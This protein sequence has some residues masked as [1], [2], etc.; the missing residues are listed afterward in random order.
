MRR[1]TRT[2]ITPPRL[3]SL[4]AARS[5]L[6]YSSRA[7]VFAADDRR[8]FRGWGTPE[9]PWLLSVEAGRER[10][11][12]EAWGAGPAPARAAVRSLFSLDHPLEE[13]YRRTRTEPALRGTER[14]F[15]GLRIP[16]DANLYEAI[17]HSLIGQQISVR[18]ANAI[19]T[20]LFE[21]FGVVLEADGVSV[22][23]PPPPS[24]L[25]RE[26]PEALRAVGLSTA[27]SRALVELAIWASHRPPTARHL[28]D[29]A[30]P[31]A[32]GAL[33][34]LRGVGRWTAENALLRGVGRRDVFVAGDLGVRVALDR[35]GGVPRGAPDEAARAW[36]ERWYPGW[37]SYATLYLWRKLVDDRAAEVGTDRLGASRRSSASVR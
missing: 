19:K 2:S 15:R 18:A 1:P 37:G 29:A 10:W 6:E 16:R 4:S 9:R 24:R 17:L 11:S 25:L 20:R 36:A 5:Q 26:G 33:E 7:L 13:F 28:A 30:L 34:R 32:R 8:L 27:K 35:Y 14:R 21:R 23:W 3:A 12:I 22:P 31:E